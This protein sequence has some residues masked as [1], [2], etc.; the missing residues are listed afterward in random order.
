MAAFAQYVP[1]FRVQI[2]GADLPAAMKNSISRISFQSGMEGSSRVEVTLANEN[3]RWLDNALFTADNSFSLAIRY[4]PDSFTSVFVGE[5]TGVETTFPSSG[6]PTLTV[7][8]HDFMQRLMTGTKDA[9]YM[10]NIPTIEQTP[11]PDPLVAALVAGI[12]LLI[13]DIDPAGAALSFL[14][15]L[16]AFAV[17]PI[18]ARRAVRVQESESDYDFL[19]RIAKANGWELYID[20]TQSPQGY[21]LR[22]Q[23]LIQ[24]YAPSVTLQWGQSLME[25][26]PRF[27]T[28]GQIAGVAV[29][30]WVA[31]IMT[32]LVVTL[33]YDYDRAAFTLQVYPSMPDLAAV[34]GSDASQYLTVEPTAP[35]LTPQKLVSELLP[36]LNNRLTGQGSCVGNLA[37]RPGKIINLVGLGDQFGG[38]YRITS[39]THT[40]DQSGYRTSF[41]VR[42]EVWFGSIPVPKG[43]GGLLIVQGQTVGS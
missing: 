8:A 1:E 29:R 32:E 12:N 43:P 40:L 16:A 39:A 25:F 41:E 34:L 3:L 22:F 2:N 33:G 14:E 42:K 31:A 30:I 19:K 10:I 4:V 6:I 37:I 36:R 15:L 35:S 27:T 11:L 9:S 7:V 17:D 18:E 23:F 21:V 38:L 28:V 5:I 26:T 20:Q 24:D 13:P